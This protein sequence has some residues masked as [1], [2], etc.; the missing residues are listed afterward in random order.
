MLLLGRP[1]AP[2]GLGLIDDVTL[3][4]ITDK[5]EKISTENGLVEPRSKY[6]KS[7]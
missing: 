3:N 4:Q 1:S 6:S 2:V 5:V 7:E